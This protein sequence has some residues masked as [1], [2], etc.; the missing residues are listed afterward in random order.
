MEFENFQKKAKATDQ[1]TDKDRSLNSSIWNLTETVGHLSRLYDEQSRLKDKDPSSQKERISKKLGDAL[2]YVSNI[3]SCMDL[4]L[5]KVAQD[6][7]DKCESR[8]GKKKK[9]QALFDISYPEDQQLPR[10]TTFK[11][12]EDERGKVRVSLELKE[13]GFIQ[14]GA[15]VTDNAYFEDG[16]RF[17]DVIHLAFMSVLGWSPVMR[18]LMS[19]KRKKDAKV[20]EVEDGARA[21]NLEE[22]VSAM[23]YEHATSVNYFETEKY[24]PFD[25]LKW[26]ERITRGLE[27]SNLTYELWNDAII[28]GYTVLRST[29]ANKGGLIDVDLNKRQ[30]KYRKA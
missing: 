30:I 23:I 1:F 12:E 17:H 27:A 18:A 15:R 3:C 25:I 7:L 19:R 11:I 29:I 22:A 28:Q 2:W 26:I 24:V 6:N 4:E 10:K 9:D 21:I 13:G 16:Y 14:L 20:D 5:D 8:W